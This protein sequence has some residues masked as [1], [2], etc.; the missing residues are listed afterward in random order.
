M[1]ENVNKTPNKGG[2]LSKINPIN[3][4][5]SSPVNQLNSDGKLNRVETTVVNP[6]ANTGFEIDKGNFD[7]HNSFIFRIAQERSK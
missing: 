7:F 3:A 4:E 6:D 1:S 2:K 5:F